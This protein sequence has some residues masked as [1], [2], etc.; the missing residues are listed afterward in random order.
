M[1]LAGW[2]VGWMAGWLDGWLHV[3]LALCP[4]ACVGMCF[5][6]SFLLS[7]NCIIFNQPNISINQLYNLGYVN[8]QFLK[9]NK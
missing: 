2:L 8:F 1:C 7:L 5:H 6:K 9:V 3:C 4:F